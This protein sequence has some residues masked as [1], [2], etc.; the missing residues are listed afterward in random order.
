MTTPSHGMAD[1]DGIRQR[2]DEEI[3]LARRELG[4]INIA[5][6]GNT[7]VGKSTLLNAVFGQDLAA[8]GSG[9]PVTAHIQYHGGPPDPLGIYDTPGFE[10]GG[11]ADTLKSEI[12]Q[13]FR[14]NASKPLAEQIHAVWFVENSQTNRFVD[15]QAALVTHLAS[16]GVP[17]MMILTR[18]RKTTEGGY[19]T[20][21]T[22]LADS[23]ISRDLP[24]TPAATLFL[25][26]AKHDPELGDPAHGLTVLLDATF[27]AVPDQVHQALTAAQRL[28]LARKRQAA[29]RVINR[30]SF[31]S[32]AAGATPIPVA[33][34]VLVTTTLTRMFAR[35][36][37]VYGIPFKRKQL[38]RLAAAVLV[39]GGASHATARAIM[40]ASSK[41]VA[42]LAASQLGKQSGKLVPVANLVVAAAAGAGSAVIARAAGHAW[43]RVCEYL[44]THPDSE[45][46]VGEEVLGVFARYFD[47]SGRQEARQITSG[48]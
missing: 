19:P 5:V 15:A 26:N 37:A 31:T 32:A 34:L 44:L 6:F 1:F 45:A 7:G 14:N 21:T 42:K 17:V 40:K 27:A 24:F 12:S 41:Q 9:S 4:T 18:V 35:I 10:I 22:S 13:V 39:T 3:G 16:F 23:I 46:L 28:D 38:A 29:Q 43:A 25:V 20:Q 11:S 8:T 30:F 48:R 33:D 47:R 2:F 36:S